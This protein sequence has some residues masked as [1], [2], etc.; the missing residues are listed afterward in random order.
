MNPDK[1]REVREGLGSVVLVGLA[2]SGDTNAWY[3]AY[4]MRSRKWIPDAVALLVIAACIVV[5]FWKIA[6]TQQYTFI[7]SPDIG[8]QVLPWLQVQAAAIHRGVVPLWD[9]YLVGGQPLAGQVQ[10][11]VFSPVTWLLWLTPLDGSGHLQLGWI[12]AWFVLLH[13]LGGWFAYAFLRSLPA[14][15]EASIVGAVFFGA[16]GFVGNTPW[17]QIAA[18]AIWLP[19]VFLFYLRSLRGERPIFNAAFAGGFLALSFLAG[20]HAVPTFAVLMIAGIGAWQRAFARTAVTLFVGAAGAAVQI[21]PAIEYAHYALRWVNSAN[22]LSWGDVVPY[23]VHQVLGWN[24]AELLFVILPGSQE[25]IVN[26]LIGVVPLTLVGIALLASPRRRGAGLLAG[27]F[28]A[29]VLFA[30]ARSNPFHGVLYALVPGLEKARAPIMAMAIADV[31]VAALCALGVAALLSAEFARLS[32]VAGALAALAGFL[33]VVSVYPP[34]ILQGVPHGAERAAAIAIVAA[35]LALLLIGWQRG[36]VGRLAFVTGLL[37][38]SLFEIGNSTGYDYVHVEDKAS[39]VRPRLYGGTTDLAKFLSG[40]IGAAR[41]TY[42]HNDLLFNLGDW[43][44]IAGMSG[45]VPSA[46]EAMRRL[47]TWN[48]QVLDLYGVR[49]YVALKPS[50]D[51]GREVFRSAGGWG[52]WER[53]NAFPRAWVVHRVTTVA[54]GDATVRKVLDAGTNLHETV[55]MNRQVPVETCGANE[56]VAV[57]TPDEGRAEMNV[58]LGCAG[59]VVLSDNWF[60]G[61]RATIDGV[62]TEVLT[63]NAALRAVA[64]PGGRHRIAMEYRPAPVYWGALLSACIFLGLGAMAWLYWRRAARDL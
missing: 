58:E 29:A 53:P 23:P 51:S 20:H 3:L 7:E 30:L 49:Y 42:E 59:I 45:F 24:A 16:A 2:G 56:P 54:P 35:L 27:I 57:R 10:P 11:A 50:A 62:A 6:L 17:P 15:P 13:V 25:A 12:H 32:R 4:F 48:S 44:G 40:R 22:P 43:Y 55:V 46:P 36:R 47:G 34:A 5:A 31:A 8:H 19:L 18:G 9:P 41:M 60:P 26:P 63:A 64:V 38:L 28:G 37:M 1:R 61:W 52:V 14:G 39:L 33:F 21:L